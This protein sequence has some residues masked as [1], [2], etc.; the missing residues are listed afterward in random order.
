VRPERRKS[1]R[2]RTDK[3]AASDADV[4][5][6]NAHSAGGIQHDDRGEA[7]WTWATEQPHALDRTFDELKALD[8]ETL[9]LLESEP[10]VARPRP[11]SGYNPYDTTTPKQRKPKTRR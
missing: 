9:T 6:T 7:R 1:G 2:R 5:L 3:P 4:T 8:N 11:G 10:V